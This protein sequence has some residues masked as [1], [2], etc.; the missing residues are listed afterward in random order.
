MRMT[1]TAF[2]AVAS[3]FVQGVGYRYYALRAAER[4]GITGYVRNLPS[5]EVETVAEG[6]RELLESL[7][8]ELRQGPSGALVRCVSVRW[9]DATGAYTH[10]NV[11]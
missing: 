1:H 5:G 6:R 7:L 10:F 3:G 2:T 11:R 4:R 8:D 9:S